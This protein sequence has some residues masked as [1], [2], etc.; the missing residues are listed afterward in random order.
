MCLGL[1]IVCDE[2]AKTMT[3]DQTQY[4]QDMLVAYRMENCTPISTPIDGYDSTGPALP[5]EPR[6]DTQLY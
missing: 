1:H 4:I 6:A 2:D 5:G 3:I